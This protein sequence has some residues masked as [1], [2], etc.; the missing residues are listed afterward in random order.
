M[1]CHNPRDFPRYNQRKYPVD[2]EASETPRILHSF[3]LQIFV[4]QKHERRHPGSEVAQCCELSEHTLERV[5]N[6]SKGTGWGSDARPIP[7]DLP[8]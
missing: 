8:Q 6:K 5:I 1:N 4:L 7:L 3:I 2:N